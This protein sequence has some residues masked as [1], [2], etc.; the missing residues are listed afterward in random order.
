MELSTQKDSHSAEYSLKQRASERAREGEQHTQKAHNVSRKGGAE[1]RAWSL[2][3]PGVHFLCA[4]MCCVV[5]IIRGFLF[6]VFHGEVESRNA[7]WKSVSGCDARDQFICSARIVVFRVVLFPLPLPFSV[8]N[9][10]QRV[11][12][13]TT[14]SRG[15][16]VQCGESKPIEVIPLPPESTLIINSNV[17]YQQ[18]GFSPPFAYFL[19][20]RFFRAFVWW[21]EAS[22][23]GNGGLIG[24]R[25]WERE[26]SVK[27]A[28][29]QN[30]NIIELHYTNITPQKPCRINLS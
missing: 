27:A 24:E 3:G 20:S 29:F 13:K 6:P 11:K 8:T 30:I 1:K 23:T 28:R 25:E 14:R 21:L 22:R 12:P 2:P 16:R 18:R 17:I 26:N 19:P 15:G 9:P 4:C 10:R 5:I 7:R